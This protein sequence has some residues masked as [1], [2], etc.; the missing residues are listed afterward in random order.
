MMN[1][2]MVMYMNQFTTLRNEEKQAIL[3]EVQIEKYKRS[4]YLLRHG[5]FPI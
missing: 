3:E 4:T 2:I 1:E 5:D